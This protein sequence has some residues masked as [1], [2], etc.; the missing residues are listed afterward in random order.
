[1]IVDS[2]VEYDSTLELVVDSLVEYGSTLDLEQQKELSS[3]TR[4][5]ADQVS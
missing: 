1:M 5:Q 4:H 3:V 2:A